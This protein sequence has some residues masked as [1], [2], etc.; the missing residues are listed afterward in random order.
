M[1]KIAAQTLV[2]DVLERERC[3]AI[4][5]LN[6]PVTAFISPNFMTFENEVFISY[7]D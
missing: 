7:V 6:S 3:F 5:V 1:L 2:D 4:D